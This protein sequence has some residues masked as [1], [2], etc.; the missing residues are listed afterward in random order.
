VIATYRYDAVGRRVRKLIGSN[1]ADPTETL[2]YYYN[3]AGQVLEVRKDGSANPLEQYVWDLRYVHTPVLRWRDSDEDEEHTLDETLYYTTDANM[4]V[5]ALV[6]ASNGSVVERVVYDPY[7]KAT[8]YDSSWANP[9]TTSAYANEVLYTGHRLDPESGLYV[10]LF[11]HYHPTLG[12]WLQRDPLGYVDGMS[13]YEYCMSAPMA[14][15]DLFGLCFV[16]LVEPPVVLEDTV[17]PVPEAVLPRPTLIPRPLPVPRTPGVLDQVK[18]S[19]EAAGRAVDSLGEAAS[20][21][22]PAAPIAGTPDP[23]PT[24]T[25]TPT[26][27]PD[28]DPNLEKPCPE[29]QPEP[30]TNPCF[31]AGTQ[32]LLAESPRDLVVAGGTN[33]GSRVFLILGGILLLGGPALWYISSFK[34]KSG[35]PSGEVAAEMPVSATLP[36]LCWVRRLLRRGLSCSRQM[37]FLCC[38]LVGGW[39][40]AIATPTLLRADGG[41]RYRTKPIE[42]VQTGDWVLAKEPADEGPPKAF[43]VMYTPRNHTYHVVHVAV[44][45]AE[46]CVELE[47]TRKHPFF[48][49]GR[50]WVFARDLRPSDRLVDA[51][52]RSVMISRVWIEDRICE[53]FN[54]TVEGVHTFY[55]VAGGQSI[56]VH[57]MSVDENGNTLRPGAPPASGP[58]VLDPD[59]KNIVRDLYKGASGPDPIGTGSTADAIRNEGKTGQPTHGKWHT[60]KGQQYARALEKWLEENQNASVADREVAQRMLDDLRSAMNGC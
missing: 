19:L 30:G 55:V 53:T 20:G 6:N 33:F 56:L 26:P 39:L 16:I 47:S 21:A 9:S 52:G 41:C 60:Q 4:N 14:E 54:L 50:G 42:Q 5:T 18:P 24:P 27:D 57:N 43:Q 40:V 31:V 8:F 11:R 29:S 44:S 37:G 28:P 2:D 46:G 48:V 15:T 51:Q 49:V 34:H 36:F 17:V 45:G 12:R 35:K 22:D 59:L 23:T 32:V 10:T 3:N 25:P 1:P 58:S 7:G 38:M 13:L